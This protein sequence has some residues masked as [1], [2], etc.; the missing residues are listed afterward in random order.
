MLELL[1]KINKW[2]LFKTHD[3]GSKLIV[4]VNGHY[5]EYNLTY[6]LNKIIHWLELW[7]GKRVFALSGKY[8][9]VYSTLCDYIL[10][11]FYLFY[12]SKAIS[13]SFN[14]NM[15]YLMI[16]SFIQIQLF[17]LIYDENMTSLYMIVF[18]YCC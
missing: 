15:I 3:L 14:K 18:S 11:V 1:E 13:I 17:H 16:S 8:I 2:I 6:L 10:M 7:L 9:L 12:T 4:V 5:N